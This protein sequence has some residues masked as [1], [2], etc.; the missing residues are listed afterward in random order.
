MVD[1]LLYAG[2]AVLMIG[3]LLALAR[4]RRL[5][6]EDYEAMKGKTNLAGNAM[7]AIQDVFE[8]QRAEALRKAK[9]ELHQEAEP[10][11]D[12]PEPGTGRPTR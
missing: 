5:S 11:G 3:G 4:P 12:P 6:D 8:P 1:L 7:Q 9:T 10:G 2:L